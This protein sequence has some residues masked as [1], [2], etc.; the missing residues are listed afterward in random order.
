MIITTK[1]T[2][3]PQFFKILDIWSNSYSVGMSQKDL[4]N[5]KDLENDVL[6]LRSKLIPPE[7]SYTQSGTGQ[8]GAP[9]K[10]ESEKAPKTLANERSLDNQMEGGS[11]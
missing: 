6:D 11:N 5:V 3:F 4:L 2:E 7:S 8:V 9:K 1:R 10:E